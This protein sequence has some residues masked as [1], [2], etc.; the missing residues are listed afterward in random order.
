MKGVKIVADIKDEPFGIRAFTIED[1]NGYQLAFS[2]Q[3]QG[4]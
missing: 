2:M 4:G 1:L 3:L